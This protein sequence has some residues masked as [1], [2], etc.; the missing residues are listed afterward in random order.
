MPL[1]LSPPSVIIGTMIVIVIVIV[2]TISSLSHRYL[3][4]AVPIIGM[5]MYM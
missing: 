1:P 4:S 3:L 2:L 5:S